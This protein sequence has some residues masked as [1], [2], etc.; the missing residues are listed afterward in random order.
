MVEGIKVAQW[1][2][3]IERLYTAKRKIG[4]RIEEL[5]GDSGTTVRIYLTCA[6]P[7]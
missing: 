5:G 4:Q 3:F 2:D 7:S 6:F 1:I